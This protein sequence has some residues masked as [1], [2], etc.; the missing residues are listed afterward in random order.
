MKNVSVNIEKLTPEQKKHL[1]EFHQPVIES[2]KIACA[3]I[4][5]PIVKVIFETVITFI[6]YLIDTI[7]AE[8]K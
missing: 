5:N 2:L 6:D 3:I 1:I 4:K 7:T 8:P